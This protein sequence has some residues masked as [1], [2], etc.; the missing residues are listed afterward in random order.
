MNVP[1]GPLEGVPK[2]I[3]LRLGKSFS[4]AW[5]I[6]LTCHCSCGTGMVTMAH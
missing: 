2:E 6:M 1:F 3:C 5:V 4:G